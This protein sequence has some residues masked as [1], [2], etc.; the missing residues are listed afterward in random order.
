MIG[1]PPAM[2]VSR[3]DFPDPLD[4]MTPTASPWWTSKL[5]PLRAWMSLRPV[6]VRVTNRSRM[7][8]RRSSK[9]S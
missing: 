9:I 6:P 1:S 8:A 2:A 5:T 7:A 4:P 3:V